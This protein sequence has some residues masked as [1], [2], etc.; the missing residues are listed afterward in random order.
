MRRVSAWT[1]VVTNNNRN[2]I[3]MRSG[4]G[5]TNPNPVARCTS[6][7]VC[8]SHESTTAPDP[9]PGPAMLGG[10]KQ[11]VALLGPRAR[12]RS[13]MLQRD[14]RSRQRHAVR[15]DCNPP[16]R[17]RHYEDERRTRDIA[18]SEAVMYESRR[19]DR[20][21]N[22]TSSY[23][24]PAS[25][26]EP[27]RPR[28]PDELATD[29]VSAFRMQAEQLATKAGGLSEI[30]ALGNWRNEKTNVENRRAELARMRQEREQDASISNEARI[31]FEQA[32][33][34]LARV[35]EF[36][37][38]AR[39]PR[40]KA[41]VNGEFA[42]ESHLNAGSASPD[43]VLAWAASLSA[44]QRH[45]LAARLTDATTT[46]KTA[47]R[48]EFGTTLANFLAS[49]RILSPFRKV[50]A[51][52]KAHFNSAAYASRNSSAAQG[53]SSESAAAATPPISPSSSEHDA[54]AGASADRGADAPIQIAE[55][56]TA[57][58]AQRQEPEA[59]IRTMVE[60][61]ESNPMMLLE[62]DGTTRRSFARRLEQYR[63]GRGDELGAHF[64]RLDHS[65]RVQLLDALHGKAPGS[66]PT[67]SATT[68]PAPAH[69]SAN[70]PADTAKSELVGDYDVQPGGMSARIRRT[71]LRQKPLQ[72]WGEVLDAMHAAGAVPWITDDKSP[73]ERFA[74]KLAARHATEDEIITFHL[75]P[76]AIAI[77]GMPQNTAP[78]IEEIGDD[79]L[80]AVP[81]IGST[82]QGE[83]LEL[84]EKQGGNPER[85]HF[86]RNALEAY[87]H[88]PVVKLDEL[89][90]VGAS[91]TTAV[92]RLHDRE[93]VEI[94][95][96]SAWEG[97]KRARHHEHQ[98]GRTG[99]T[100]PTHDGPAH[101][102]APQT[103]AVPADASTTA[104]PTTAG[105]AKAHELDAGERAHLE[106]W[107]VANHA[108]APRALT[109]GVYEQVLDIEKDP[110]LAAAVRQY[111]QRGKGHDR[112]LD[113]FAL[114]AAV[115]R[116]CVDM[117]RDRLGL[118]DL[119]R[120]TMMEVAFGALQESDPFDTAAVP[121]RLVERGLII[122][123]RS[124]HF[125]VA[126]DWAA[127][128]GS[129]DAAFANRNWHSVV[130]WAFE[131]VDVQGPSNT[132]GKPIAA[133]EKAQT[134]HM[135]NEIGLDHTFHLAPHEKS[136]TWVV[137]AFLHTSHFAPKHVMTTVEVKTEAGRM[138][139]LRNE[140]FGGIA[141]ANATTSAHDFDLAAGNSI[142]DAVHVDSLQGPDPDREGTITRGELPTNFQP[143]T[144][145]DRA[146]N[147][148]DEINRTEQLIEYLGRLGDAKYADAL[149]AA[150]RRLERLQHADAELNKDADA[151]WKPFEVRG[152]YLSLRSE[153]PSGALDLYGSVRRVRTITPMGPFERVL[154]QIRDHSEK[155]GPELPTH[156]GDGATFEAALQDTFVK[157][158]KEYPEGKVAIM[159]EAM[160]AS[161]TNAAPTH[162]AIGFELSTN[163]PWKRAKEM[164][165]NPTVQTVVNVAATALMIFQPELAPAILSILTISNT[166][167]NV[168]DLVQHY[169]NHTLTKGHRNLTLA[170]IGLDFL[171]FLRGAR[172]LQSQGMLVAFEAANHA[173]QLVVM[174]LH[175]RDA[176]AQI[177]EGDIA[178][179][180]EQY[181]ELIE[182]QKTTNPSDPQMMERQ[183]AIAERQ[184]GVDA[185]AERIR[186]RVL[187]EWS[188]AIGENGIYIVGAHVMTGMQRS[189]V[190]GG[191]N[192]WGPGRNNVGIGDEASFNGGTD[193][194]VR[195][196]DTQHGPTHDASDV[197][198]S[199]QHDHAQATAGNEHASGTETHEAP[200]VRA[201]DDGATAQENAHASADAAS[202]AG[203][204]EIVDHT[205]TTATQAEHALT[206]HAPTEHPQNEHAATDHAATEHAA[207]EHATT[208]TIAPAR[209]RT[210]EEHSRE[211]AQHR[212]DERL[213]GSPTEHELAEARA[214]AEAEAAMTLA[215][216]ASTISLGHARSE[217]HML[218]AVK[219]GE[220]PRFIARVGPASQ[221]PTFGNP[222]R[223]FIFA[224]E[225]ADLRGVTPAEALYKVGW[226]RDWTQP[227]I[228]KE[229]EV[230]IVDT[231]A[232]SPEAVP[233]GANAGM[234]VGRMEW[235][236]LKNAALADRTF[237]E[238]IDGRG[239]SPR[240]AA[241]L[242]DIAAE[243][244][245]S[246]A[247]SRAGGARAEKMEWLLEILDNRYSVNNLFTGI[248][249]T[250]N[251]GRE[252]GGREVMV[253]PN[254]TRFGLT[255]TNH[256]KVS[257]GVMTQED[258]NRVFGARSTPT[259]GA[260]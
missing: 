141:P 198:A 194:G 86:I 190:G 193:G 57:A 158:A 167:R 72:H 229:I 56:E 67:A 46:V 224:T 33:A 168:D 169:E 148:Q 163:T 239:I 11:D 18:G 208:E 248:G 173:G 154:V 130:E 181:R 24:S 152:T 235:V 134:E 78:M 69:S 175:T 60:S 125:D 8:I 14:E 196:T 80:I 73:L 200:T 162:K 118:G 199:E 95:G 156:T 20:D 245:I 111:L 227:N 87:T 256:T 165:Y 97:W 47:D 41:P 153:I 197:H 203:T 71:W 34:A 99:A 81:G 132:D 233:N 244:P 185:G 151:G 177:Q 127:Y 92:M 54:E 236:D 240:E 237:L 79:L 183:R 31:A 164:L 83:T 140:A 204:S 133:P 124:V 128:R 53:A 137:H 43:D 51:D 223:A 3:V 68:A 40:P 139:D 114:R 217:Q 61:G 147:R 59:L 77:I 105:S 100:H 253:R 231:H 35:D 160:D 7:I 251:E 21:Y 10:G 94:F 186:E 28:T 242:F 58:L 189:S 52:P 88:L 76:I 15:D 136:G 122:D 232:L 82:G 143:R 258:F 55:P 215:Q 179:L 32:N 226:G 30:V 26:S 170:Q 243:G 106:A 238:N 113:E 84:S 29:R 135:T 108:G 180:A 178:G 36:L 259:G 6:A 182:L 90:V 209:A 230:T 17:S 70:A 184:R 62:I 102:A 91:T 116:A 16:L 252:L 161:T 174:G 207:T 96:R 65:T 159:A 101:D 126:L 222:N 260:Q 221:Y 115:D 75:D 149:A 172:I 103:T 98:S 48:D 188:K 138:E 120:S 112:A 255:P 107:F 93:L 155:L 250:M 45:A 219:N 191:D 212:I 27:V 225:P 64:A 2:R 213:G 145:E 19:G 74:R 206:E 211:V 176:L 202:Q 142:V 66:R 187:Q 150:H 192:S 49:A 121:A 218:L 37:K 23:A 13:R 89:G 38:T 110:K 42:I 129:S 9:P 241:E 5:C 166:I 25:T 39:E 249:A 216:Q 22:H 228:G 205:R 171:P 4:F 146:E 44:A 247:V 85:L 50:L 12:L 109:R 254:G 234:E 246:E 1:A 117:E 210:A 123:G 144:A 257:L 195:P 104:S 63:P 201:H 220:V 131:R 157:L 214:H 119:K